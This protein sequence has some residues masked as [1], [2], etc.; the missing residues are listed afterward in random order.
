MMS[1]WETLLAIAG[2]ALITI[3]TRG[4]FMMPERETPALPGWVRPS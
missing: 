4:F 3:V 1:S 2:L